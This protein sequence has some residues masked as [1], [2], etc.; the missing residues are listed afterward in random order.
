M[1]DSRRFVSFSKINAPF[2]L[3]A[4]DLYAFSYFYDRA[5][6]AG[7]VPEHTGGKARVRDFRLAAET[8]D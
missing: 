2:E 5:M 3:A 1:D 6:Q 4:R 7:I 8:G